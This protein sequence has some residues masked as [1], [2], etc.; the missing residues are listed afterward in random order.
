MGEGQ[1]I[2]LQ[3]TGQL[4]GRVRVLGTNETRRKVLRPVGLELRLRKG[5]DQRPMGNLD[6][7]NMAVVVVVLGGS[8]VKAIANVENNGA[9]LEFFPFLSHL[10]H[11]LSSCAIMK[12]P[13][14]LTSPNLITACGCQ[15][16]LHL[17]YPVAMKA[18]GLLAVNL[19]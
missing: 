13:I 1:P 18:C 6:L 14:P 2:R 19:E 12:S 17:H 9:N 4:F 10:E 16:G 7:V 15:N 11:P 8:G 3:P 5:R